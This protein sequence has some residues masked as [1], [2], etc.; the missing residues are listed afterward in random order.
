VFC[1]RLLH[2]L[3]DS[4]RPGLNQHHAVVHDSVSRACMKRRDQIVGQRLSK[5]L[6]IHVAQFAADP[7]LNRARNFRRVA[8]LTVPRQWSPRLRSAAANLD[9]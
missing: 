3:N 8:T 4:A 7:I 9:Y 2:D 1:S 6:G 5:K